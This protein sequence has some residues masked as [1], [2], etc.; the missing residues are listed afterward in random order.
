VFSRDGAW[1]VSAGRAPGVCLW[2]L[3]AG[4]LARV[5]ASG[6]GGAV[7]IAPDGKRIAAVAN[8]R[9]HVW[10]PA[11]KEVWTQGGDRV[12][13]RLA[14]RSGDSLATAYIKPIARIGKQLV[15]DVRSRVYLSDWQLPAGKESDPLDLGPREPSGSPILGRGGLIV[16]HTIAEYGQREQLTYFQAGRR[17]T[18]RHIDVVGQHVSVLC[19]S[20]DGRMLA[21][22]GDVWST[23]RD[24][25]YIRVFEL[26]TGK[27]RCRF[28]SVDTGQLSLAFAPDGRTLAS[29][30]LD[31]T[32]LLWDLTHG[33]AIAK[34]PLT[35]AD[36]DRLWN[37]LKGS[38]AALAYRVHWKL[39]AASMQAVP[40]LARKVHPVTAPDPKRVAALVNNLAAEQFDTRTQAYA[41]LSKLE[42]LAEPALR[43]GF[44]VRKSLEA[45]RRIEELLRRIDELSPERR[46]ALRAIEALEHIGTTAAAALLRELAAGC[47]AASV[48]RAAQEAR[49]RLERGKTP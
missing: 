47:P 49:R 27:E 17:D 38:D 16:Q 24:V 12:Y 14:F 41:E 19:V 15:P 40:F 25:K 20:P 6:N 33:E 43:A 23:D 8:G 30:S 26:A 9:L 46:A 3:R 48:T 34:A 10:D 32:V 5:L 36:L 11:G 42:D 35:E 28:R 39:V 7:A 1:L 4:R 45:H 22:S 18:A 37:D 2:D 21:L 31:V 29:G 13:T 44:E